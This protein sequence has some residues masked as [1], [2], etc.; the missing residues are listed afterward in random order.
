[1]E[2][3]GNNRW[4]RFR[5]FLNKKYRL[6]ILNDTT[7]AEKFS[8]KMSPWGI[9][10]GASALTILITTLAISFVAFTPLR[11]YIPGYGSVYERKLILALNV[12]ADS[13]EK[14]LNARDM[15]LTSVLNVMH[16]KVETQTERAKKDTS[17]KYR[18]VNTKPSGTDVEF[19]KEYEKNRGNAAANVA[20][21]KYSGIS[22]LVFF[23]P[24][25]GMVV[26]SFNIPEEHFGADIVTRQDETIKTTLDGTVVFTGFSAEDGNIIHVQ[27]SNNLLSIYKHCSAL[28]KQTG[29]RVRAGEAIAVVGNTGEK[30]HGPHL[31]FELWF[32][33]API[34]PEEFVP[35]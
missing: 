18:Q 11:E 29:D 20:R 34:N 17:G 33:G 6:V 2:G 9:I 10:I 26:T 27:H 21:L 25:K 22:E 31:H 23:S 7:F 8:L 15:Y 24:V 12:M 1:M 4:K 13:L 30:S 32:N 5:R 19:R 3:V 16:E 35:F 28:M 14:T